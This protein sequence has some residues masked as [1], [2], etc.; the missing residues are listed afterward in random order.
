[1]TALGDFQVQLENFRRET[2]LSAQYIYADM[3]M[4]HAAS[5][6]KKLLSRLND[7]PRFWT[8]CAAS[9]QSAAYVSIARIFDTK[10]P[11]NINRLLDSMEENLSI[12]QREALA[13]RKRDGKAEDPEWLEEYL[14]N[15]YYPTTIDVNELRKK[16]YSNN[17][18]TII[19]TMRCI[20]AGFNCIDAD[21]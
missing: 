10:S 11:Y 16:V 17:N 5:K 8:T 3:S 20:S 19:N 2:T 21:T 4:Q 15:A 7:N 12:F 14:L 1:M 18:N 9:L 6:S 13:I